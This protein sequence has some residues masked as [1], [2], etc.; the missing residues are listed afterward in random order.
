VTFLVVT[1]L[2]ITLR[3]PAFWAVVVALLVR[4]SVLAQLHAHPLLQP[5]GGLDS[6][7]YARLAE[8]AAGGDWALGPEP[9]FVSPLYIYFLALLRRAFGPS[10]VLPKVTQALL[11]AA[12]VGL[13]AATARRLFA[14]CGAAGVAAWLAALLGVFVFHEI[15]LLQSSLDP[16]LTSLALFLLVR[17]AQGAGILG[18][19]LPGAAFGLLVANRPNALLPAA[20]V[21]LTVVAVGRSRRSLL[22]AATLGA[23]LLIVLAPFALRTRLVAGE[24]ILVS[25]HGGLNFYIGNNPEADGTYHS[26]PGI[27][28]AIEGQAKDARHLAEKALGRPL[29]ASQVSGYF[30]DR[31]LD[32]IREEPRAAV[33]LLANKVAYAL[34][35]VEVPLNYSYA[36]FSRDEPTLLRVLVVGS[37]LLV[38]LGLVGLLVHPPVVSRSAWAA[39]AAFV[40]AYVLSLALFFV[41]ARYRLPLLVPLCV[42]A[43]AAVVQLVTWLRSGKARHVLVAGA[44]LAAMLLFCNWNLGLDDGR[45]HQAAEMVLQHLAAGREAEAKALLA[46][47]EPLL[48]N[49]GLLRYRMGLGYVERGQTA[50]AVPFFEGAL[51]AEP[52]QLDIRLSLGQALLA[53][54]QAGAAEPHLRAARDGGLAA[55]EA[56]Y[57]LARALAALGRGPEAAQVLAGAIAALPPGDG[58]ALAL[59]LFAMSLEAPAVAEPGLRLAIRAEPSSA[60]AHE[61]LGLA[62]A[63]LGRGAEVRAE[64]EA[65]C[66]LDPASAT[67]RFNL[68]VLSLREGRRDEAA[69][70]AAEALRLRPDYAPARDLLTGLVAKR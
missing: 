70:L 18:Y 15:V 60:P 41:S 52:G 55:V 35:A 12:A 64:L 67:A 27:M 2:P 37:W 45:G 6:A 46:R 44:G 25:S 43:G 10:L 47:T 58:R 54:G 40:P 16:F 8:R 4:L 24:W 19:A 7:V 9:Y 49:P 57:D 13:V 22:Q 30:Y 33:T 17:A 34:N 68:A 21:A 32:F 38:P 42:S 39:W 36:Y 50:E 20:A 14:S 28:P 29:S 51:Q 5:T 26:V 66:R 3:S 63:Q 11:G 62:L 69:R 48:D 53:A 59:G 1:R 56:G 23:F 31:A 65:A 61:A